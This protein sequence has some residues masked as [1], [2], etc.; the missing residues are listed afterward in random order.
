MIDLNKLR[1][2]LENITEDDFKEYFRN[3]PKIPKGWVSI[4]DHLPKWLAIDLERGYSSYKVRDING[5]EFK[6][7]VTDHSLW[8]VQAR[9]M[10]ITHWLNV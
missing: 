4:D 6:T 2:K 8:E 1:E 10:N 3:K 5:N 7:T 9:E